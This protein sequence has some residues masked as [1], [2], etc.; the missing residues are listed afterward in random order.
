MGE[1]L[2]WCWGDEAFGG[3]LEESG[4]KVMGFREQLKR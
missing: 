4:E 3:C 2:V 1:N